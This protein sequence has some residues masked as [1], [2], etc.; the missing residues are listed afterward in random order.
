MYPIK[1]EHKG[2][3]LF[4]GELI[5]KGSFVMQYVGEVFSVDSE[6]GQ[7]RILKYKNSTCT[8]L[9]RTHENEVIDPTN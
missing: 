7:S 3:G 9:M 1:T 8:Y 5:L 6:I 4:A 2:C